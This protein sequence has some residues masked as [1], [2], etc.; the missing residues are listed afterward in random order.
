M[1]GDAGKCKTAA[2][3]TAAACAIQASNV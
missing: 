1:R 3:V 2:V